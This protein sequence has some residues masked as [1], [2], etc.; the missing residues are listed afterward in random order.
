LYKDRQTSK[1]FFGIQ[2]QST[3]YQTLDGI[4]RI[5]E[6][7]NEYF[8]K[9]RLAKGLKEFPLMQQVKGNIRSKLEKS[10][11]EEIQLTD[12]KLT[13]ETR[14][15]SSNPDELIMNGSRT[16][17]IESYNLNDELIYSA[18][19]QFIDKEINSKIKYLEFNVED[20]LTH[21]PIRNALFKFDV[22]APSQSELAGMYFTEELQ[23]YAERFISPYLTGKETIECDESINVPVY[24]PSRIKV[25]VVNP[26]Y[27]FVLGDF[28]IKNAEQKTVRM[29]DKGQKVR[30]ESTSGSLGSIN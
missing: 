25:E 15:T 9:E 27:N 10:I 28:E 29:V 1:I 7:L 3:T 16:A 14:E 5:K 20:E 12:V 22:T 13:I 21:V 26:D 17:K 19:E 23:E 8:T 11:L 30:V 24:C 2:G 4:V 6:G 18:V